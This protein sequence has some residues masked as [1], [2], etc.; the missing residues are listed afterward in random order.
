MQAHE[1]DGSFV[2]P[3]ACDSGT[4]SNPLMRP[5][6]GD[7]RSWSPAWPLYLLGLMSARMTGSRA[8]APRSPPACTCTWGDHVAPAGHPRAAPVE[9][10]RGSYGVPVVPAPRN[11]ST[12]SPS[13]P[14]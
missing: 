9:M 3:L 2:P 11:E 7:C 4:L 14:V 1:F 10:D 12:I 6:Y 13:V 5:E 8:S